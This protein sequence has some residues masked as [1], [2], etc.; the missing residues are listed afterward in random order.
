[1]QFNL[2]I[3]FTHKYNQTTD[4]HNKILAN[5]ISLKRKILANQK[6]AHIQNNYEKR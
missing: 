3:I 2:T 4:I 1:M 5:D 6:Y